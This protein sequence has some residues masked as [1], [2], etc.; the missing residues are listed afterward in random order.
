M[1]ADDDNEDIKKGRRCRA[2]PQIV[3]K[4][5]WIPRNEGPGGEGSIGPGLPKSANR[6]QKRAGLT[7]GC[8]GH[9]WHLVGSEVAEDDSLRQPTTASPQH[10][11]RKTE[12]T[13]VPFG[14]RLVC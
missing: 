9:G 12:A 7:A 8:D 5:I 10:E 11:S 13:D 4:S 2:E 1:R 6:G 14:G 3:E